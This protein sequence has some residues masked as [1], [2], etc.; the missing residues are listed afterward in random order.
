M[1]LCGG[2]WNVPGMCYISTN[3]DAIN[4]V[5]RSV[6]V[7]HI[8]WAR[9]SV[10]HVES[11]FQGHPY[12]EIS[13]FWA[14]TPLS[15]TSGYHVRV[16]SMFWWLESIDLIKSYHFHYSFIFWIVKLGELWRFEKWK[17]S[18]V[19]TFSVFLYV[20]FGQIVPNN[21]KLHWLCT[22]K[23][24]SIYNKCYMWCLWIICAVLCTLYS[25]LWYS[26]II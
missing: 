17:F 16:S 13:N 12:I 20:H 25:I 11:T 9:L 23:Y 22:L 18:I 15:P 26:T 24:C 1:V 8:V 4:I 10:R 3:I 6:P 2:T 5:L 7:R 14:K 19:R 21:T